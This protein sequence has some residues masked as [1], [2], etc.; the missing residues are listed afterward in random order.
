MKKMIAT[1]CF[2]FNGYAYG[3]TAFKKLENR[4]L[5]DDNLVKYAALY[6][7]KKVTATLDQS[8]S[9]DGF[10]FA[11]AYLN[12]HFPDVKDNTE[13]A[14]VILNKMDDGQELSNQIEADSCWFYD[15]QD[16]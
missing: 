12:F 1:L 15:I 6:G 10:V 11:V 3:T 8:P 9:D 4:I 16:N 5:S 14:N 7:A 13:E 2:Q